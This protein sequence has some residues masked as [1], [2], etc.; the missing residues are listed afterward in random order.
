MKNIRL[1]RHGQSAAN[2]GAASRDH[3]TI[4]L[5]DKGREQARDIAQSITQAPDLIIVSP[6]LRAQDT[7]AVT[8]S[9]FPDVP[10][11]TWPIEE[12]TYLAP[13]RCVDTTVAQRKQWVDQYWAD[14]D[15]AYVDGEGAE[16]L[17]QRTGRASAFLD[18]LAAHPAQ[19]ILVFSHGQFLSLVAWL[20]E[21]GPAPIDGQAMR[22]WRR[23]EIDNHL[24]NGGSYRISRT[25]DDS[26]WETHHPRK[27]FIDRN[28]KEKAVEAAFAALARNHY[29]SD[30]PDPADN[31]FAVVERL[32]RKGR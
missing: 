24:A 3:A 32:M 8:A 18:R 29:E 28:P 5:T 31:A 23:Y 14:A 6:F 1:L 7:A 4:P 11:E 27:S 17:L 15:P 12:F 16:S 9:R 22:E 10:V 13:A 30:R 19:A 26:A 25:Q 20:I 21:G 2:A